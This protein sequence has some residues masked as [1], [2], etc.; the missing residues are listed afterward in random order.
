MTPRQWLDDFRAFWREVRHP[1]PM[2]GLTGFPSTVA[3]LRALLPDLPVGATLAVYGPDTPELGAALAAHDLA[4]VRKRA[5]Q[6]AEVP[7]T[8]ALLDE[9]ASLEEPGFSIALAYFVH[10][11][12]DARERSLVQSF[13]GDLAAFCDLSLGQAVLTRVA[14]ETGARLSWPT[15]ADP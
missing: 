8:R 7:L 11:S 15:A 10:A 6:Y 3:F 9:L 12:G 13:D 5:R 2:A 4:G 1:T 14:R